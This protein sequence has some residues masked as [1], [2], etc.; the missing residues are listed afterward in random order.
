MKENRISIIIDR[1]IREVFEFT[2]NP[3]NTPRWIKHLTVEEAGDYPPRI[4][5]I[6][7]NRGNSEIWAEYVVANFKQDKIFELSDRDG[8]Y[9]VRYTYN[10]LGENNKTEMEY[11]EWVKK[12]ELNQP[13]TQ[14][15]LDELKREIERN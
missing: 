11:F 10:E 3:K 5:T 6:Y 4:G 12:G 2:V 15:I 7:R 1:P 13:F 8:N 9:C 14:G